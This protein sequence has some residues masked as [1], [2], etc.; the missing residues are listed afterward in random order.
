MEASI[1]NSDRVDF[2]ARLFIKNKEVHYIMIKLPVLQDIAVLNVCAP[3]NRA[4]KYM[5]KKLIDLLGGNIEEH[6]ED[7][8]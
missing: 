5:R 7:F 1:L 4:S 3:N 6:I 8:G 2:R